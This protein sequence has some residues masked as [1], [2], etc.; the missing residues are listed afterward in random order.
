MLYRRFRLL[1]IK[2]DFKYYIMG[3]SE[4][5]EDLRT[6]HPGD[7]T[8][9]GCLGTSVSSLPLTPEF[10]EVSLVYH[11]RYA[12]QIH[13][14]SFLLNSALNQ[15]LASSYPEIPARIT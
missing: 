4:K 12:H 6:R 7:C 5:L 11:T 8:G 15:G 9:C 3:P 1:R 2:G 10:Q 13:P 14:G